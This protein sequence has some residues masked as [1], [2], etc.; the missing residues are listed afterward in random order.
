MT[1]TTTTTQLWYGGELRAEHDSDGTTYKYAYGPDGIPLGM[2]AA[3]ASGVKTYDYLVDHG[4]SV[5]G[6]VD[7]AGNRLTREIV[8]LVPSSEPPRH[9]RE[10]DRQSLSGSRASACT[11]CVR[12]WRRGESNSGPQLSPREHLQA[13]PSLQFR[14]EGQVTANVPLS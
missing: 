2:T 13:Q 5:I 8:T 6:M 11:P 14:S 3:T 1:G 10:P 4:G 9:A 12:W 7:D